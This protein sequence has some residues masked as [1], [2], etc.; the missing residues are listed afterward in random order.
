MKL[1][2]RHT[3][4]YSYAR[5]MRTLVQSVRL[6][7]S[8]FEGQSAPEWE[9]SVEGFGEG[10]PAGQMQSMRQ[11][12]TA[13]GGSQVQVLATGERAHIGA[14]FR[15]GAGDWTETISVRGPV[16]RLIITVSG[17]VE[18]TDTTGVLRGHREGVP[19]G[20]Y[21]RSTRAT[22]ADVALT[23]I[24]RE[25]LAREE[26]SG[27]LGIAHALSDAVADAIEYAPGETEA[28]TTAAEA[29][30]RGKGVCQDH[31][32]A[33]IAMAH[34]ARL[35]ARYVVGYLFAEPGEE[36]VEA[37]H[38]WAELWID[39]LGWVGFDP[40]NRCCPDGRYVRLC[41]GYDAQDAAP[42]RGVAMGEETETLDV[43]V[44]VTRLDQ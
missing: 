44:A 26:G 21:L 24:A 13:P 11:G 40:A 3:T 20:T 12:G 33:L 39:R 6:F 10:P 31:A 27:Q 43:D 8:I 4:S 37:S 23:E 25:V 1:S 2:I 32:H 28:G 18:T 34:I 30:A 22:V 35:P 42:I 17:V 29:L 15:D 9:V 36:S 41:S 5:P 19:P 38:A 14:A 7:P 16:D